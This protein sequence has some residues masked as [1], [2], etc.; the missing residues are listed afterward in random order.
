M[1]LATAFFHLI[2]ER[3][4]ELWL[5][6]GEHLMLTGLSTLFA[7]LLGIPLGIWAYKHRA[8]RG[9]LTGA[10]GILQTVPSLAM[11]A[12]LLALLQTIGAVPAIIAL[13]LYALLPIMRNTLT[14]LEGVPEPV[15]EAAQGLGMTA[16]QRLLPGAA[17]DRRR[18]PHRRGGGRRHRHAVGF[19]RRGRPGAVHQPRP[20]AQ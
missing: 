10:V 14:G 3:S 12:I 8:L 9:L 2:G 6:T 1:I 4:G 15:L 7:I 13:T 17:G 16:Q 5:R 19:H 18:H 20:G 11:L